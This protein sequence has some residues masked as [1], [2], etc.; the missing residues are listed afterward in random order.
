MRL[1]AIDPSST[2]TGLAIFDGDRLID[3]SVI[4]AEKHLAWKFEPDP[5]ANA[6]SMACQVRDII[7]GDA[8]TEV[9]I[10]LNAPAPFEAGMAM[11]DYAAAVGMIYLACID[12]LGRDRVKGVRVG[13]WTAGRGSK[14]ERQRRVGLLHPEY[15]G[16][17]D[18]GKDASDA[19]DLGHWYLDGANAK[20][21]QTKGQKRRAWKKAIE[22]TGLFAG[23]RG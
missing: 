12:V 6:W 8:I 22:T 5:F 23:G 13:T 14:A 9:V 7:R 20:V 19:C 15:T 3:L 4:T 18:G 17:G 21:P 16:K 2:R 11:C 1:L 10:E